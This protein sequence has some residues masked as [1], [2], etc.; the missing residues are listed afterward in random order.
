MI[1]SND[2]IRAAFR[3]L[4]IGNTEADTHPGPE[5]LF[6]YLDRKLRVDDAERVREHLAFCP[7]CSRLVLN[8][9]R[10]PGVR[11][12][13]GKSPSRGAVS[14]AWKDFRDRLDEGELEPEESEEAVPRANAPLVLW[15]PVGFQKV[16]PAIAAALLILCLGLSG[17]V[18]SLRQKIETVSQPKVHVHLTD[19]VPVGEAAIRARD[20]RVEVRVPEWA[21]RLVVILNL[22]ESGSYA[23]Y[24]ADISEAPPTGRRQVWSHQDLR[25][26]PDRNFVIELPREFLPAGSYRIDLFGVEGGQR[27]RL[28]EYLLALDFH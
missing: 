8:L 3:E 19:L 12:L 6:A 14:R 16:L 10:F 9:K 28:A 20:S 17:W 27:V 4:A 25:Q 18:V 21:D 13:Q 22:F 7:H 11:P 1:A 23:E 24:H 5:D 15:P 2:E 26:S